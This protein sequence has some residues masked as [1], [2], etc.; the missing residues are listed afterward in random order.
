MNVVVL[1]MGALD[2]IPMSICSRGFTMVY[3]QWCF[4]P[5]GIFTYVFVFSV[6]LIHIMLQTCSEPM[7]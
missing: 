5:D 6:W 2:G 4:L 1:A 3:L 7:R